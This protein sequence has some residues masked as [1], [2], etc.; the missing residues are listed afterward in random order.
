MGCSQ[1]EAAEEMARVQT[2]WNQ[3]ATVM[4]AA[5]D[6]KTYKATDAIV[7]EGKQLEADLAGWLLTTQ[8]KIVAAGTPIVGG[9]FAPDYCV[10][11]AEAKQFFDRVLSFSRRFSTSTGEP[12]PV[13]KYIPPTVPW[14]IWDYAKLGIVVVAGYFAWRWAKEALFSD[15]Y[16][17]DRLPQYAGGKR[18]RR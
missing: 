13:E 16:P 14:G 11:K 5:A 17:V 18:K 3:L 10:I 4:K 8:Q 15:A 9:F 12:N 6:K 1:Q 7:G 2:S